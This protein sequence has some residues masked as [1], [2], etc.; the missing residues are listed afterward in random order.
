MFGFYKFYGLLKYILAKEKKKKFPPSVSIKCAHSHVCSCMSWHTCRGW[1]VLEYI[2]WQ[3]VL[4]FNPM[5]WGSNSGS[6]GWWQQVFLL[7]HLVSLL[8][9]F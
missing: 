3:S 6:Q 5:S 7:S 8:P 1:S 9:K 4:S 2:F